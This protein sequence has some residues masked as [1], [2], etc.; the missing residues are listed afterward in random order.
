MTAAWNLPGPTSWRETDRRPAVALALAVH[1][2]L[3]LAVG[4]ASL[5]SVHP[6]GPGPE[7]VGVFW[8]PTPPPPE[9]AAPG[10]GEAQ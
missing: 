7:M 3:L 10:S 5:L 9:P 4:L 1:G 2:G 6:P 8:I